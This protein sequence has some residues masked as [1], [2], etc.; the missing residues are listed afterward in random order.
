M[1]FSSYAFSSSAFFARPQFT[2]RAFS[3]SKFVPFLLPPQLDRHT[4]A[5]RGSPNLL[6]IGQC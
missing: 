6:G 2:K 3:F 1:A 4:L 5:K